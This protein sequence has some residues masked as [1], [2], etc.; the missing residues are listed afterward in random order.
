MIPFEG[1]LPYAVI[2][3][4]ISV[5][6]GGLSALHS[7]KNNGKRDRY[8]LDQWERQ[9]LQRDFRLTGK[10]REQSDKAIAPDSFKTSS[11]WKAEKPF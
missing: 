5:A 8:N 10:Y 9:M 11:W 3:G 4:L 1:L 7:I 6:G 2:F